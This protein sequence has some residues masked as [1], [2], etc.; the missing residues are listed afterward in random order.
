VAPGDVERSSA[1]LLTAQLVLSAASLE[2]IFQSI[3][4]ISQALD[5]EEQGEILVRRE[6]QRLDTVRK[7]AARFAPPTVVMLEW[8]DPVFAMG[9]WGPELVEIGERQAS[10][11]TKRRILSRHSWRAA[12][13][14]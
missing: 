3:R 7:E 4:L 14:C 6:R 11:W 8:T 13:V 10:T 12:S 5:L 2:E 9:N 1:C